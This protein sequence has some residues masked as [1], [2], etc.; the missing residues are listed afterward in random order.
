KS[1]KDAIQWY[2]SSSMAMMINGHKSPISM[3]VHVNQKIN[4]HSHMEEVILDYLHSV[5]TRNLEKFLYET[6]MVYLTE[7]SEFSKEDF[8]EGMPGYSRDSNEIPEYPSWPE[9][10][11]KLRILFFREEEEFVSKIPMEQDGSLK[12]HKG[13][14]LCIDNSAAKYSPN[15]HVRIVYPEGKNKP[16]H[17]TLFIVIGGNTLSRGLTLEGLTTTYFMRNTL[18]SDTLMQMGR[19]FGY[20]KGYE[21]YPRIW[22]NE[23]AHERFKFI[24]QLDQELRETIEDYAERKASPSDYGVMVKNS[25]N[26]KFIQVTSRNKQQGATPTEMDFQG[27]NK[28]TILFEDNQEVLNHNIKITKQFLENLGKPKVNGSRIVWENIDFQLVKTYFL[29]QYKAPKQDVMFS[30]LDALIEWCDSLTGDNRYDS[31]NIVLS[32]KGEIEQNAENSDWFVAGYGVSN[33][34]RSVLIEKEGQ[35]RLVNIGSLRAP[36]DLLSDI[37]EGKDSE[38]TRT[39]SMKQVRQI[40]RENNINHIPQLVIYRINKDSKPKIQTKKN[41]RSNL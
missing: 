32:S 13:I 6:K 4:S 9:I 19:W 17:A 30:N 5:K 24:A 34:D 36:K 15:E 16:K 28:Q 37:T 18:M 23:V 29:S 31:W 27:I 39:L 14:H 20:R 25:A 22:M 3:L 26:N 10:E 8:I 41:K 40:R 33:V 7:T 12:F 1:L 35:P 11:D 21:I 38:H 2:L